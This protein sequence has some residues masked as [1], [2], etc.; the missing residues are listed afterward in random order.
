MESEILFLCRAN[1][2][3]GA[4]HVRRSIDWANSINSMGI[5]ASMS[6]TNDIDWLKTLVPKGMW[7]ELSEIDLEPKMVIVDSY[8]EIFLKE[9]FSRFP[10]SKK[11]QIADSNS[12]LMDGYDVIWVDHTYPP[13]AI[14]EKNNRVLAS[15][16]NLLPIR[17]FPNNEVFCDT[18]KNVLVTFGGTSSGKFADLF[19]DTFPFGD[20]AQVKFHLFCDSSELALPPNVKS[21]SLGVAMDVVSGQCDTVISASGTSVWNFVAN[22]KVLGVVTIVDNQ[23]S[24]SLYVST[25]GFGLLLGSLGEGQGLRVDLLDQLLFDSQTRINMCNKDRSWIGFTGAVH[26]AETVVGIL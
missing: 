19:L 4:G 23:R 13:L 15:G 5:K 11:I 16:L 18:A 20:Y 12:K 3:V 17:P 24:N 26:F 6:G 1:N 8:D 25:R 10:A 9:C 7:I 21:Y 22:R 2:V 14:P